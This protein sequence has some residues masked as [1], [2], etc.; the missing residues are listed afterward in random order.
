MLVLNLVD[1][2]NLKIF[3]LKPFSELD[4][5]TLFYASICGLIFS[6]SSAE[7]I[8]I[9]LIVSL[10]AIYYLRIL[11]MNRVITGDTANYITSG[12]YVLKTSLAMFSFQN[13]SHDGSLTGRLIVL[14][15][16]LY[17]FI[18]IIKFTLVFERVSLRQ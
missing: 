11:I 10:P 12:Y 8:T 5:F 4:V 18:N 9:G 7:V 1:L 16:V 6:G 13:V 14:I 15:L 2:L 3:K 17:L